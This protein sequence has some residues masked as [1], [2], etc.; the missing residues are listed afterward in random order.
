MAFVYTFPSLLL[1]KRKKTPMQIRGRKNS[2][3]QVVQY[4][5]SYQNKILAQ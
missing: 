5:T 4:L 1:I 2:I 3:L